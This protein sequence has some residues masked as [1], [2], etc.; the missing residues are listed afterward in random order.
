MTIGITNKAPVRA[1]LAALHK[2]NPVRAALFMDRLKEHAF[3]A[4]SPESALDSVLSTM[5]AARSQSYEAGNAFR[6]IVAAARDPERPCTVLKGLGE[7]ERAWLVKAAALEK[8]SVLRRAISAEP[9]T[10]GGAV[11]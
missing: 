5:G 8:L 3:P 9:Q 4:K 7:I 2:I 6:A 11:L 1:A 10:H